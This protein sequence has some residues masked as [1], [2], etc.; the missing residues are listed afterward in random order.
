MDY[1]NIFVKNLP[2]SKETYEADIQEFFGK[3]IGYFKALVLDKLGNRDIHAYMAEKLFELRKTEDIN[4]DSLAKL[5]R[6][7]IYL[8]YGIVNSQHDASLPENGNGAFK[9]EYEFVEPAYLHIKNLKRT[10]CALDHGCGSGWQG[11]ILW[12]L[13]YKVTF[14]D[15]D[16]DYFNFLQFCCKKYKIED[17]NFIT[18]SRDLDLKNNYYEFIN[19]FFV[20]EHVLYP[21]KVL[22][23]LVAHLKTNSLFNLR[24]DFGGGGIHLLE[25][26][27]LHENVS[28]NLFEMIVNS[29][30]LKRISQ[31]S[32]ILYKVSF[33]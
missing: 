1:N 12:R 15:F 20:L 25:N 9:N 16:T 24:T 28:Q 5:Y 27:I 18:I 6:D 21:I 4:Q 8:A 10:C 22:K 29:Y 30:G 23:E 14:C 3:S 17:V 19:S 7:D 13:G 31:Y 2:F 26:Y 33:I 11:L 32:R